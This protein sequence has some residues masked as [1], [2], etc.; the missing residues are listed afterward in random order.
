MIDDKLSQQ[1]YISKTC[2]CTKDQNNINYIDEL[3]R[4]ALAGVHVRV[5]VIGCRLMSYVSVE[6]CVCVRA[7]ECMH[8]CLEGRVVLI[9]H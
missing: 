3:S 7:R 2:R 4:I 9:T 1:S 5:L 8:A 6:L